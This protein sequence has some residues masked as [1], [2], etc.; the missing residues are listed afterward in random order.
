MIY[1]L[2]YA[3]LMHEFIEPE[4]GAFRELMHPCMESQFQRISKDPLEIFT[5]DEDGGL[6]F[7]EFYYNQAVPLFAE[8]IYAI[9]KQEETA[10]LFVRRVTVT[11]KLQECSVP[12]IMALPPRIAV[13]DD[14]GKINEQRVGNCCMFKTEDLADHSIYVTEQLYES[15]SAAKPLGMELLH[16]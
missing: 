1:R 9:L 5:S 4:K 7:P 3:S 8:R 15:L 6:E 10:H 13:L 14:S 2:H 11:D 16:V 12:Y